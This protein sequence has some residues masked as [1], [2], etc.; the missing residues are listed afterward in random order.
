MIQKLGQLGD[1][2]SLPEPG[3]HAGSQGLGSDPLIGCLRQ[4]AQALLLDEP[5]AGLDLKY[6]VDMLRLVQAMARE[7]QLIVIITLHDLNYAS[8]Y[9]DRVALLYDQS[10]VAVG[11]PVEVLTEETIGKVFGVPVVIARHPVYGTPMVVPSIDLPSGTTVEGE[12]Q[13]SPNQ[14]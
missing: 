11:K 6:Q 5:T 9:G 14:A 3:R 8:I 13:E 4:Q 2:T 12:H 1:P 7:S 10:L